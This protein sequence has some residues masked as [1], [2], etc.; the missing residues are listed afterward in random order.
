MVTL[1]K[2]FFFFCTP[3]KQANQGLSGTLTKP[4]KKEILD[5]TK[6]LYEICD[7]VSEF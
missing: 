5:S 3:Q 2:Y 1:E 6:G 7:L 4:L